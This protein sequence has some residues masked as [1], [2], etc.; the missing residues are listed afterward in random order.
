MGD[1][2]FWK[3]DIIAEEALLSMAGSGDIILFTG[4]HFGAR[5]TRSVTQSNWDHVAMIVK[6]EGEEDDITF[7][8]ATGAGVGFN[9]WTTLKKYRDRLYSKVVYRKLY[10]ERDNEMLDGLEKFVNEAYGKKYA[11]N[12][13]KLL[14]KKS[15]PVTGGATIA[16]DR[17]FF[18]S[19]L[20]A[21]AYKCMGILPDDKASSNYYPNWFSSEKKLPLLKDAVLGPELIVYDKNQK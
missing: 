12:A 2:K 8:E 7:I 3:Q 18:C 5:V 21:K 14:S 15:I 6:F 16:E 4:K 20:V 19:E 13:T 1:E 9:D 11:L 17:T 10:V